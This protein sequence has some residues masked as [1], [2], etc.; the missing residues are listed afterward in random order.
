[1]LLRSL[2]DIIALTD[3]IL[4]QPAQAWECQAEMF[5]LKKLSITCCL[6]WTNIELNFVYVEWR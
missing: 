3:L 2:A 1:M 5:E 6:N 4:Q